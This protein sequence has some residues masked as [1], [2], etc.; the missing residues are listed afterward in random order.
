MR[1]HH[2]GSGRAVVIPADWGTNHAGVAEGTM[3][4]LVA[5]SARAT[6][7]WDDTVKRTVTT[8]VDPFAAN[9]PARV[10]AELGRGAALKA[11][12]DAV[13]DLV[14]VDGYLI[15]VPRSFA[16]DEQLAIGTLI[17]VTGG[18]DTLLAGRVLRVTD[19][20]RGTN[21]FE[22]NLLATLND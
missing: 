21:R 9:I 14:R 18:D 8:L 5:F 6:S 1:H 11:Q 13:D 2:G 15:A 16:G 19:I 20:V 12:D 7:A 17:S 10:Q 22:R 3:L 4:A